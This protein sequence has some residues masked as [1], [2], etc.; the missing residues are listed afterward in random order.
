MIC[1]IDFPDIHDNDV[2]SRWR[3]RFAH[4]H[5]LLVAHT[6]ADV[7]DVIAQ[8]EQAARDEHWVVGFVAYEAAAAFDAALQTRPPSGALPFAAFAVYAYDEPVAETAESSAPD[9]GPWTMVDSQD[10]IIDDIGT[11]RA[12]IDAGEYYQVNYTTRLQS[13]FVGELPELYGA[14][15]R[16]QPDGFCACL[17]GGDWQLA[18]VSPELFFDWTPDRTLTTR[19]MKGTSARNADIALPDSAKDRAENL[20]IVDLLRNDMARVAETGSVQ[21]TRL[22]D[23]ETLPTALQ[24]TSTV[25]CKT[26]P[27]TS[28]LDIFRALFPCGS[29][30]GAPKVAAMQAIAALESSARGAYCG[31]IG[32]IRPNGHATFNVGIRTVIVDR[33]QQMASCGVGSGITLDSAP[34]SE[35]AEWLV[36]RRF[37]LRATAGF[38]LLATMRLEHGQYWLLDGHLRRL[39]SSAEHF[40]FAYSPTRVEQA[41]RAVA[42]QH[43]TGI[44]RVRLTCD[45][46]GEASL[47]CALLNPMPDVVSIALASAPVD[48]RNE[49][50]RY[51]T[52]ERAA[53]A[54]HAPP[55]NVFDTLLYN[56]RGEIT[57]FT[58]GNVVIELE[59]KQLTPA[60]SCGLLPGVMRQT[61]LT[62]GEVSEAVITRR[63]IRRATRIWFLNSVRGRLLAQLQ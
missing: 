29:V 60:S 23:V 21:V 16:A 17:D 51:K 46:G 62:T 25:R 57:E 39:R 48:S 11:I 61:W 14:L 38:K 34:D 41:L 20:M 24:M 22:F 44:W 36:K 18:S 52:T 10:K 63:D 15:R 49:F 33:Q 8:A 12:A 53:Y 58:R 7:S 54:V 43:P 28:L 27:E 5:R 13:A 50:L 32:V 2:G 4:P 47:E 59:G 30:T 37:L 26:P 6:L 3:A 55:S 9:V 42:V 19:P 45:R 31:A 40:G 56:E 1:E 35:Y